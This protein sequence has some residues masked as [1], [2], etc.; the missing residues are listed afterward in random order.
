MLATGKPVQLKDVQNIVGE[1]VAN[2][3]M[4][5]KEGAQIIA[6]AAATPPDQ[7][8]N[9]AKQYYAMAQRSAQMLAPQPT[10]VDNGQTIG[11]VN[12]N[13]MASVPVGQPLAGFQ[14]TLSPGEN[15]QQVPV[16]GPNNTPAIMSL[17]DVLKAQQAGKSAGSQG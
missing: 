9:K 1:V 6:D 3:A 15:A 13:P 4:T 16:M 14:K 10:A 7:L 8:T 12:T 17:S 11:L 5:A 2:H